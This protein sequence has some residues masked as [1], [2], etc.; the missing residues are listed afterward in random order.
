M[1]CPLLFP[2]LKGIRIPSGNE[3]GAN[4]NWVPEGFTSGGVSEAVA[5]LQEVV[6]IIRE[7]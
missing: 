5:D 6:F 4:A 7:F 2:E 1:A 3:G